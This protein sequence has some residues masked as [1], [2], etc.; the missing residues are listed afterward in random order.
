MSLK[1]SGPVPAHLL[2]EL[3]PPRLSFSG[4][5]GAI[6]QLSYFHSTRLFPLR[7]YGQVRNLKFRRQIHDRESRYRTAKRLTLRR[8]PPFCS[9]VQPWPSTKFPP[10]PNRRAR[11]RQSLTDTA[12]DR[13]VK[14]QRS[15]TATNRLSDRNESHWGSTPASTRCT[16]CVPNARSSHFKASS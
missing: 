3:L 2:Q 6:G 14:P 1:I 4:T 10:P 5:A 12:A 13:P 16:S 9:R 11:F 7:G 8:M 15:S